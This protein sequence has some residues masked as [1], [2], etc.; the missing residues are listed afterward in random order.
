MSLTRGQAIDQ[1]SALFSDV[2]TPTGFPVKYDNV[3]A[4]SSPPDTET[5]WA[6]FV[7]RH[8]PSAQ[9]T[10]S[11]DEGARIFTREG[12]ITV[13]VF[14][15]TGSGLIGDPADLPT[16]VRDA[17]EGQRTAG[18]AWFKNVRINEIGEDGRWFQTNVI[19]EFEYDEIK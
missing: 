12:I 4:K 8:G 7:L 17:Y 13:Q 14:T 11:N 2:W 18:G 5:P 10:L 6:R 3:S 19:A 9:S 16:I 15:L 1:M